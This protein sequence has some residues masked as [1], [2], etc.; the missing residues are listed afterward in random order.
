MKYTITIYSDMR[1]KH[2]IATHETDTFDELLDVIADQLSN[3]L[4]CKFVD[5]E[6]PIYTGVAYARIGGK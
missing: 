3:G 5:N 4:H 6:N 1:M 2:I